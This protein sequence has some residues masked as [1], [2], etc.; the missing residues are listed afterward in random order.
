MMMLKALIKEE[1][2]FILI[3]VIIVFV[4][5]GVL[6]SLA[7]PRFIGSLEKARGD[8][9]VTW[10]R[11]I[12][13]GEKMYRLDHNTFTN[14]LSGLADYIGELDPD[15]DWTY[16]DPDTTDD[17]NDSGPDFTATATRSGGAYKDGTIIIDE[18]GD[19]TTGG[20]WPFAY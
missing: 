10:L 2:G 7:I 9:A 13:I 6:A 8:K 15:P 16:G 1:K 5:L 3:E 18:D 19:I 20:G 17:A 4:I 12:R 11:L 14:S